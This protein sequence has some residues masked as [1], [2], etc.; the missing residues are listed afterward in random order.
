MIDIEAVLDRMRDGSYGVCLVCEKRIP[1]ARLTAIPYAQ[2]CI[3]CQ[4]NDHQGRDIGEQVMRH[5]TGCRGTHR[6]RSN[7]KF[8]FFERQYF[9]AYQAAC[10]NPS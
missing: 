9:T 2:L 6:A 10:A 8:S 5:D 4:R 3:D 1:A 7:D